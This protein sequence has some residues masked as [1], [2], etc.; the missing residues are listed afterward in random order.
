MSFV[1]I[2][3]TMKKSRISRVSKKKQ[4]IIRQEN[5]LRDK[6][7]EECGG[8]CMICKKKPDWRGLCKNH[9]KDRKNFVLSCYPCHS[10]GGVH[11]VHSVHRFLEDVWKYREKLKEYEE[12]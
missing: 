8:L 12:I 5:I 6:M 3:K 1:D 9:T 7:L 10:P 11:S 4:A 2:Q